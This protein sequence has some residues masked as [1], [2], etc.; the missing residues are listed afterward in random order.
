MKPAEF[1]PLMDVNLLRDFADVVY[2]LTFTEKPDYDG[3]RFI[4]V[5]CLLD[6][7]HVPSK[8]MD[9]H[10]PAAM[11]PNFMDNA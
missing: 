9:W 3:L 11:V 5:K 7:N 4:L 6:R 2:L 10:F 8:K 1:C